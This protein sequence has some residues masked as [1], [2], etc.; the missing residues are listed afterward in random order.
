MLHQDDGKSAA[1]ESRDSTHPIRDASIFHYS[2]T[3]K[4]GDPSHLTLFDAAREPYRLTS[5]Q[6]SALNGLRGCFLNNYQDW[7]DATIGKGTVTPVARWH[8]KQCE[9]PPFEL[10][11]SCLQL[12]SCLNDSGIMIYYEHNYN[13]CRY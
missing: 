8:G 11:E 3:Q 10:L 13:S 9:G 12:R 6:H 1:I 5:L 2:G 7:F 4:L